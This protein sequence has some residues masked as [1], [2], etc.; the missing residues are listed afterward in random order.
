MMNEVFVSA[1]H[2]LEL[3]GDWSDLPEYY[4]RNAGRVI[5][6]A[7]DVPE[8]VIEIQAYVLSTQR[9]EIVSLDRECSESFES[10]SELQPTTPQTD[11]LFL[12][13]AALRFWRQVFLERNEALDR[14]FILRAGKG[15]RLVTKSTA[16]V[17]SGLGTS[18]I[19]GAGILLAVSYLGGCPLEAIDAC[20]RTYEMERA[21][22]LGSGWQDQVGGIIPGIKDIT[23]TQHNQLNVEDI[24]PPE[25]FIDQFAR[26]TV[27]AF[28]NQ[29]RF[30]GVVLN[31]VNDLI[32]SSPRARS[33]IDSLK[34]ICDSA[35]Q[36]VCM[37]QYDQI[38][39]HFRRMTNLQRGLHPSIIPDFVV[40]I[41][42]KTENLCYG[43][44]ICGAGGSGFLVFFSRGDH[45]KTALLRLL[46]TAGYRSY[47][48]TFGQGARIV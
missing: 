24:N 3:A 37:G 7:I 9:I 8:L 26:C 32:Q 5:N 16:P 11:P 48:C 47:S 36:A 14:E 43:A 35:K 38:G 15:I 40:D 12:P 1:S 29:T 23:C 6:V 30:S 25:S 46:E 31:Q 28:T 19:L 10:L 20:W 17:G 41:F 42:G 18:S 22:G 34:S 27:L 21:S 39:Y 2:R 45:E 33:I 44:R 4:L 13:K